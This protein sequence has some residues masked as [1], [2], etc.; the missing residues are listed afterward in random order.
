MPKQIKTV[1]V[2]IP[3]RLY[4]YL[5]RIA[6]ETD[7]TVDYYVREA[8]EEHVEEIKD[9]TEA[10]NIIE[11]GITRTYTLEEVEQHRQSR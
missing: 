3:E 11:K 10:L 1:D 9:A 5:E 8:V 2:S 4:K 6:K 7:R